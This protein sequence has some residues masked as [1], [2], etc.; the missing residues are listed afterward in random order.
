MKDRESTGESSGAST[1]ASNQ[2]RVFVA[3]ELP[4]DV[5]DLLE[6]VEIRLKRR[7]VNALGSRSADESLKWVN[8]DGVHITLKFLGY[9]A[10]DRIEIIEGAL[11][12]ATG[13]QSR[14]RL[15]VDG[16][17][18]FPTLN[19]PRVVWAG[20][21]G[22]LGRLSVLQSQVEGAMERLGFPE[23]KRG[24][25]PHLTLARVRETASIGEMR[26][27]GQAVKEFSNTSV[28]PRPIEV[29]AV[30]LMRSELSRQGARYSRLA[31]F[32][33]AK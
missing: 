4:G 7:M 15:S 8:P 18:G 21:K 1:R 12:Q 26:L 13:D 3:I 31:N 25:T 5:K 33:L 22:D 24:F 14:F 27:I 29:G 28:E 11:H 23:E 2:I 30:S 19:R 10:A 6:D 9:V 17:G 20:V 32:E 16:V